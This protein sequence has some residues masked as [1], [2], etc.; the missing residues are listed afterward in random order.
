[1][2][3]LANKTLIRSILKFALV[4][5]VISLLTLAALEIS[6]RVIGEFDAS[7]QFVYLGRAITPGLPRDLIDSAIQEYLDQKSEVTLIPDAAT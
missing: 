7:G 2:G 4:F 5:S 6:I 3:N 1:M